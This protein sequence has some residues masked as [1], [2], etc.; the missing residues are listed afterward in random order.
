MEVIDFGLSAKNKM[1]TMELFEMHVMSKLWTP[2][3]NAISLESFHLLTSY[4]LKDGHIDFGLSAK[5]KM[6]A[7]K[8]LKTMLSFILC[9]KEDK[10]Y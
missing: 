6:D 4:Y 9:P 2:L 8:I 10:W 7:I 1:A 5:S 3:V